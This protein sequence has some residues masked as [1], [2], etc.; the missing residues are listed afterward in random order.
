MNQRTEQLSQASEQAYDVLVIGGGIN[1]AASAAAL[2]G[3]GAKVVLV[4]SRDFAGFTSSESSNLIWGGIKY[5]E[6]LEVGLVRQL[7]M[8]RNELMRAYP[9]VIQ[10]TRFFTAIERKF[11]FPARFFWIG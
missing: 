2:S 1:G 8:G 4:D 6:S 5:L 9:Q 7:C 10:E 3:A 11:R